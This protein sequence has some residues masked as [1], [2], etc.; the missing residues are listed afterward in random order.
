MGIFGI[1]SVACG[2]L[3]LHAPHFRLLQWRLSALI[4]W[5]RGGLLSSPAP[6]ICSQMTTYNLSSC[7]ANLYKPRQGTLLTVS[8]IS[9]HSS[10]SVPVAWNARSI[11]W[12]WVPEPYFWFQSKSCL[13][14]QR[15]NFVQKWYKVKNFQ[16]ALIRNNQCRQHYCY[17]I[18]ATWFST[19]EVPNVYIPSTIKW[20]NSSIRLEN[21]IEE[22]VHP[23]W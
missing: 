18:H 14:V 1:N 4:V 7:S 3:S 16:P 10:K 12:C 20:Q 15:V 8:E 21:R 17:F 9:E 11:G 22:C 2:N 23:K 6:R 19:S 5:R 13:V